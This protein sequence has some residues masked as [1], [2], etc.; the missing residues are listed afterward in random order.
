[1]LPLHECALFWNKEQ[2]QVSGFDKLK[3]LSVTGGGP[4]YLEEILPNQSAETNI[5]RL[6]FQREGFLFTG[7]ER[8]FSD[9]FSTCMATYKKIVK[10]LA[11]GACEL[12]DIYKALGVEKGGVV[13]SYLNDLVTAGFVSHDFT[14]HLHTGMDSKLSH[15]RLKDNYLRFYLK[16]IEPN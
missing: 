5:Q 2:D 16:Y 3:V 1:E 11:E 13:S 8:I 10:R 4:R 7:F 12:K 9:L 6:C 14:W 15:Y